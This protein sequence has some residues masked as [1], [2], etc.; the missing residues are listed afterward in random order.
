MG[1]DALNGGWWWGGGSCLEQVSE[2]G[3][4]DPVV[5]TWFRK[6]EVLQTSV[7]NL[8]GVSKA[9]IHP[10]FPGGIRAGLTKGMSRNLPRLRPRAATPPGL[11]ECVAP[12]QCVAERAPVWVQ[13]P[14]H[15]A[16]DHAREHPVE[17]G[18]D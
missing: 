14:F 1:A 11:T 7:G 2:N 17:I 6:D 16:Q 3:R 13:R 8:P 15:K 10:C 4:T 12:T 5:K 18:R 9:R